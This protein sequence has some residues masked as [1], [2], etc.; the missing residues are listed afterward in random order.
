MSEK[1]ISPVETGGLLTASADDPRWDHVAEC[2]SCRSLVA[3]YQAFMNGNP[4][5]A[6]GDADGELDRR[7]AAEIQPQVSVVGKTRSWRGPIFGASL[8]LAAVLATVVIFSDSGVD[9]EPGRI[10]I[11]GDDPS[12]DESL[13]THPVRQ[14]SAHEL[15][16]SWSAVTGARLYVVTL[17]AGDLSE[18]GRWTVTADTLLTI[19]LP[20]ELS[21][22]QAHYWQV[23]ALDLAGAVARSALVALPLR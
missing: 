14:V 18:I 10:V 23:E 11:R 19:S 7:L 17:V 12:P 6:D 8:A 21:P 15:E 3:S 13:R 5:L 1:C 22:D 9:S 4:D 2:P 20:A 16:F